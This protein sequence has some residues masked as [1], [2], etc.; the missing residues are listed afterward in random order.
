MIRAFRKS[1]LTTVGIFAASVVLA[2]LVWVRDRGLPVYIPLIASVLM[3]LLGV[4]VGRLAGALVADSC[5]T[6]L[7]GLLHVDLDPDAFLRQYSEIPGR[8]KPDSRERLV[9]GAYLA[10]GYAAKGEFDAAIAALAPLEQ[11]DLAQD[12]ALRGLYL[13]NLCGYRLCKG[14]RAGGT[15]ALDELDKL[16]AGCGEKQAKLAQNLSGTAGLL[17]ARLTCLRGRAVDRA[18]L[19]QQLWQAPFRLRRLDILQ[20]LAQDA[21]R[22]L[23]PEQ[24]AP[25]LARLQEEGGKTW[26][27]AWAREQLALLKGGPAN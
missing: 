23:G 14:D 20:I 5:N 25:L 9:A 11:A 7:L 21:L 19:E 18:S 8:L 13:Q 15:Q 10:D 3:L 24:S 6:R 17:R 22:R 26:Y 1:R 16:I 27:A 4:F 2:V 12:T